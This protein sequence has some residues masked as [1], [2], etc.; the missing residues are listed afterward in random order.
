[1]KELRN[2]YT[3]HLREPFAKEF[4]RSHWWEAEGS[5]PLSP[6]SSLYELARRH[7]KV[8]ELRAK[9]CRKTWY[10]QDLDNL[11]H[12]P[13]RDRLYDAQY[14]DLGQEPKP[15][16]CLCLIGHQSWPALSGRDRDYWKASAGKIKGVDCRDV[17]ERCI[18]LDTMACGR[19]AVAKMRTAKAALDVALKNYSPSSE[20]L[21]KEIASLAIDEHRQGNWL[22][23]IAPDLKHDEARSLLAVAYSQIQKIAVTPKK[24]TRWEN[25]LPIITSFERDER[26][27]G[28]AK[29]TVFTSYRKIMRGIEFA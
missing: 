8:G 13:A 18:S 14:D 3:W 6:V 17:N 26:S 24:R 10:A 22:F 7:P 1:V 19:L 5:T 12:G 29:S 27:H 21:E 23:S 16:H 15:L 4:D 25:W 2:Q 9:H 20:E 11:P 28:G